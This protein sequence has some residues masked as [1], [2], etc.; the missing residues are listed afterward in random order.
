MLSLTREERETIISWSDED[1]DK[2]WIYSTQQPMI[3]RL[4]R[5]PLFEL[6]SE[7]YNKNY[8]YYPNP[9]SVEGYLPRKALTIR[10][11]RIEL[12]R[13]EKESRAKRLRIAHK[14]PKGSRFSNLNGSTNGLILVRGNS[15]KNE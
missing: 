12:S 11:K 4:R 1:G 5:N 9:I 13:E 6:K 7:G 2:I 14:S 8:K 15:C 3:R 10:T